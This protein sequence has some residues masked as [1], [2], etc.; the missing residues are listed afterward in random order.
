[1]LLS[2]RTRAFP[3]LIQLAAIHERLKQFAAASEAYEKVLTINAN[4]APALNN[5][6]VIYSEHLGQSDKAYDLAKKA[7]DIAPNEP[8]IGDT[9]GWITFKRGDYS[10]ALRLLQES[11]SKL[12]N[13]PV[14]QFHVGMADYMLGEEERARAALQKAS[15]AG[16]DFPGKDQARQRLA[17]L[18]INTGSA[19]AAARKELEDYLREQPNDPVALVRLAGLQERDGAMDEAA[20]TY[21]KVLADYPQFAPAARQ[22]ALL[23]ARSAVD[24]AKAYDLTLK[25]RQAY[26]DDAEIAKALGILSYRRDYY[27]RSAELLQEAAAKM[28]DDPELLFYLGEAQYQ[29]KQLNECKGTLERALTLNLAPTLADEAKRVLENC[30][31]APQ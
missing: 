14:I 3:R 1:M 21:E 19:N 24:V 29:L 5:L 13:S 17:V 15:A 25:A 2:S 31:E 30:S 22:L 8:T 12:P 18:A 23:Y 6:A 10:N 27:P 16:E 9:L 4:F 26:P 11:V 20:K 7:K 28:K